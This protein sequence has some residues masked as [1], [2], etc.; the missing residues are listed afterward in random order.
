MKMKGK[1]SFKMF[2]TILG[3][4]IWQVVCW[5]AGMFGYNDKSTYGKVVRR[6]F[7]GSV[8]IVALVF[9]AVVAYAGYSAVKED[10]Q[11]RIYRKSELSERQLSQ[12]ISYMQ[13]YYTWHDS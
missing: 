1:V 9:A 4:G 10:I 7:A 6:I 3:R 8:A 13:N 5:V 2:F 12:N 11:E